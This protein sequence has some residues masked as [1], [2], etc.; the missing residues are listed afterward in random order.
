MILNRLAAVWRIRKIRI[1]LLVVALLVGIVVGYLFLRRPVVYRRTKQ[2]DLISGR[3]RQTKYILHVPLIRRIEDTAVSKMLSTSN[4]LASGERWVLNTDEEFFLYGKWGYTSYRYSG[5]IED[6]KTLAQFWR[7]GGFSEAARQ[8]TAHQLLLAMQLGGSSSASH[9]Y[10]VRL[11]DILWPDALDN[12]TTD[13]GDIPDDLVERVIQ[14]LK[15][16][17]MLY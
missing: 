9:L 8:K 12:R 4:R 15:K 14:E 17:G 7:L 2:L 5:V 13:A 11:Q 16:Q 1:S 6:T 10:M 3:I